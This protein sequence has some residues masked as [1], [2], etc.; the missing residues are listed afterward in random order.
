VYSRTFLADGQGI[1][2]R[3]VVLMSLGLLDQK[4]MAMDLKISVRQ[5]REYQ[6]YGIVP[7]I[8]LKRFVRF[9]PAKVRAALDKFERKAR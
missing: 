6:R 4:T 7:F 2:R 5:L 8:K 3:Y 9:D 1:T